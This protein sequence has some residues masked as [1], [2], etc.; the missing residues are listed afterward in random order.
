[1]KSK[2]GWI[3]AAA[4]VLAAAGWLL[5]RW[6]EERGAQ[7]EIDEAV[8]RV[9]SQIADPQHLSDGR[10]ELDRI[11]KRAPDHREALTLR[12]EVLFHLSLYEEAQADLT[13]ALHSTKGVERAEI[14]L[15][16]GRVLHQRYRGSGS[17]ELFRLAYNAF[18]EA[19]QVP[20]TKAASLFELGVLYVEKGKNRNLEKAITLLQQLIDQFPDAPDAPAARELV[21][22]LKAATAKEGG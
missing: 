6:S 3:V 7:R 1:V 13:K 22:K 9:R 17:E 8:A 12:G 20:Q 4:V 18:Y 15:W 21:A 14:Q 5:H 19:Q 10:V 2:V 11:L 16:L